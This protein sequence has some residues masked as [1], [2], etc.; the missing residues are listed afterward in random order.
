MVVLSHAILN[1]T[2]FKKKSSNIYDTKYLLLDSLK[3]NFT[4]SFGVTD[5]DTFPYRVD[6]T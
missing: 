1:L 3:Y 6:Q 4:V 5:I 2:I